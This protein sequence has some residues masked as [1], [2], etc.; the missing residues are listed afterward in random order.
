MDAICCCIA[1]VMQREAQRRAIR[2]IIIIA[3]VLRL[4][5]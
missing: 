1:D 5:G 4:D 2:R 3:S